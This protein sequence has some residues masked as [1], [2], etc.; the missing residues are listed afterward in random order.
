MGSIP[1]PGLDVLLP[2][3]K[4]A[5]ASLQW[6]KDGGEFIPHPATWLQ[7]ARWLDEGTP[8]VATADPYAKF[9]R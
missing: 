7:Q 8:D 4:R 9:P 2:A 5:M 6:T 1:I 3:L